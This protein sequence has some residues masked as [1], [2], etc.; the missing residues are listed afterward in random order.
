MTDTL[1]TTTPAGS[2]SEA[3]IKFQLDRLAAGTEAPISGRPVPIN[4]NDVD[5]ETSAAERRRV[6][7]ELFRDDGEL[8]DAAD[9]LWMSDRQPATTQVQP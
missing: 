4:G 1:S 3:D 8:K 2:K 7:A 6:N 5:V 9:M